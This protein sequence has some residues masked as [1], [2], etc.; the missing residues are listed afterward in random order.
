MIEDIRI[1]T[2]TPAQVQHELGEY[3]ASHPKAA[4]LSSAVTVTQPAPL[5][6]L[7]KT[8]PAAKK[9]AKGGSKAASP[10]PDAAL[11][12][13]KSRITPAKPVTT[14]SVIVGIQY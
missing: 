14:V 9:A 7:E 3:L 10:D 2:G 11:P 8:K 4:I 1:L 12:A 5:V 6:T 13:V